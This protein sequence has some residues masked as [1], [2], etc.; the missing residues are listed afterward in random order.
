MSAFLHFFGVRCIRHWHRFA[1]P[2]GYTFF[3]PYQPSSRAQ[4]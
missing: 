2:G 3:T 1:V 4:Q